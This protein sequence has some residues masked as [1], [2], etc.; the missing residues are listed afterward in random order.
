VGDAMSREAMIQRAVL[1]AVPLYDYSGI[2]EVLGTNAYLKGL[3][4]GDYVRCT[5]CK[6]VRSEYAKLV[7]Q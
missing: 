1:N 4:S 6:V 3:T 5:F 7:A 2:R